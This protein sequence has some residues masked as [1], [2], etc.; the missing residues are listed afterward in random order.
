MS[1][2]WGSL[3]IFISYRRSDTSGHA[4]RLFDAITA[5]YPQWDIYMDVD[6]IEPGLDFVE[7]LENAV[8]SCDVVL[9]LIG[10]GWLGSTSGTS[11]PRLQDVND[12]VRLEIDAALARGIRVIP[13][14]VQG[15][16]MPTPEELP[17][18]TR[19]LARRNALELS[20]LRWHYDC[21]QLLDVLDRL[22]DLHEPSNELGG[23][24]IDPLRAPRGSTSSDDLAADSPSHAPI[25]G[26]TEPDPAVHEVVSGVDRAKRPA[27]G[28]TARTLGS[29]S[30]AARVSNLVVVGCV[31][32]GGI[33]FIAIH[34]LH[35]APNPPVP[36]QR[37]STRVEVASATSSNG[38]RYSQWIQTQGWEA[39]QPIALKAAN[40]R[41]G[42]YFGPGLSALAAQLARQ[43]R[44][45]DVGPMT[46]AHRIAGADIVIDLGAHLHFTPPS[47]LTPVEGRKAWLPDPY[48]CGGSQSPNTESEFRPS[49]RYAV[50]ASIHLWSEPRTSSLPLAV[51]NVAPSSYG[52]PGIG[53]ASP[54]DPEVK[55]LCQLRG[56]TMYGPFSPNTEDYIWFQAIWKGERGYVTHMWVYTKQD[57]LPKYIHE[58][59]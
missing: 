43:L 11:G 47:I 56:V 50:T 12:F 18:S 13:I 57:D 31:V 42:V 49:H 34:S 24:S 26:G 3:R 41:T 30:R 39:L 8:G 7:S 14:L 28:K 10:R 5:N 25:S 2:G 16:C 20:D 15:A 58:C 22:Q 59:Q 33:A 27:E 51:I 6:A 23:S 35:A 37:S 1:L 29:R 44:I 17:E 45:G 52:T 4:G 32:L 19:G 40:V 21:E 38:I 53:C 48:K 54:R 36:R 9:A 55:V 46:A